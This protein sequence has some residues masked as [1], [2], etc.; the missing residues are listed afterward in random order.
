MPETAWQ[1]L[2]YLTPFPFTHGSTERGGEDPGFRKLLSRTS[3]LVTTFRHPKTSTW[4]GGLGLDTLHGTK[5]SQK[6]ERKLDLG[7][8]AL[9]GILC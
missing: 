1:I 7:K 5:I 9:D 2:T 3:E 8:L 6:M 4:S